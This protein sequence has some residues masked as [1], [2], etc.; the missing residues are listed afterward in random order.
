MGFFICNKLDKRPVTI[1]APRFIKMDD[2]D[3]FIRFYNKVSNTDIIDG[4]NLLQMPMGKP[5]IDSIYAGIKLIEDLKCNVIPHI[6]L[7]IES[8]YTLITKLLAGTC[9]GIKNYLILGGDIKLQRGLTVYDALEIINK[10]NMGYMEIE[11]KKYDIENIKIYP[12]G[13]LIP[14]RDNEV[15]IAL[16][17]IR[18]GVKFFQTQIDYN[19]DRFKAILHEI[20][21]R[22]DKEKI[23]IL[24]GIL[25][26]IDK[27]I[28]NM[29]GE[30]VF[31]DIPNSVIRRVLKDV[32]HN[33]EYIENF[34]NELISIESGLDNINLGVHI[35]PIR[36]Y[37][38]D[39]QYLSDV[40]R[41]VSKLI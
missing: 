27:N 30:K 21:M 13:A 17:K 28:I 8:K 35:M 29:L 11:G 31:R 32:N 19:L 23:P 4:I 36:W 16:A 9:H 33:L 24:A 6:S 20:D 40:L 10:L 26:I 37:K 1:E 5:T 3:R 18:F 38:F 14:S 7:G 34:L 15:E 22:M 2:I 25:P 12:G 41:I 39:P